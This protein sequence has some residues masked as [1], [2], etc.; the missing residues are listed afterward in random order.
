MVDWS[1]E[2]RQA[3]AETR[4]VHEKHQSVHSLPNQPKERNP[5][6]F[7]KVAGALGNNVSSFDMSIQIFDLDRLIEYRK[8]QLKG[9][10]RDQLFSFDGLT[11]GT[12][13]AFRIHYQLY[14][15]GT[16][17][18]HELKTKQE[19]IVRT[20]ETQQ[21]DPTKIN[22]SIAYI[23]DLFLTKDNI[24]IGVASVFKD[25]KKVITVI[26]PELR[27][28]KG[29]LKPLAQQVIHHA[30]FHFD[31]TPLGDSDKTCSRICVFP[32]LRVAIQNRTSETFRGKE[33][34]G[35]IDEAQKLLSSEGERIDPLRWLI[36]SLL[37]LRIFSSPTEF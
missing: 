36:A 20:K 25:T 21:E 12:W 4:T 27:C 24:Y 37:L 31:L 11:P 22:D 6:R 5:I 13:F 8:T 16:Q 1:H 34:C 10:T 33:W 14:Y 28:S 15:E 26:V 19:I 18:Q 29:V 23:D 9:S 35:S 17:P 32:F 2:N 7:C 30:S 3:F